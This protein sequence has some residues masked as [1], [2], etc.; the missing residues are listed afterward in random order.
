MIPPTKECPRNHLFPPARLES[1]DSW[2][3]SE[4]GYEFSLRFENGRDP[5][6]TKRLMCPG[7]KANLRNLGNC[8]IK[9]EWDKFE[10]WLHA[11]VDT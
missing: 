10:E 5:F 3:P 8:L 11:N 6:L 1:T 7:D 2:Y 4:P 9:R